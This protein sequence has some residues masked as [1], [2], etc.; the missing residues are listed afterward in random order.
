MKRCFLRAEPSR[1]LLCR[2]ELRLAS[3]VARQHLDDARVGRGPVTASAVT[4]RVSTVTQQFNHRWK[5]RFLHVRSRVYMRD[6]S[7]FTSSSR[8]WTAVG[9]SW[10]ASCEQSSCKD[11]KCDVKT[12]CVLLCS[13]VW[14]V[15]LSKTLV[16]C[17][18]RSIAGKRLVE[19]ES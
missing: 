16:V 17:M 14:G 10:V 12:F 7:S 18:L 9:I 1:S 13:N 5:K 2:D 11:L 19:R 15:W 8:W 6:W 4:S 3:F